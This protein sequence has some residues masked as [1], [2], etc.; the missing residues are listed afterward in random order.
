[1][2]AYNSAKLRKAGKDSKAAEWCKNTIGAFEKYRTT[3]KMVEGKN[4]AFGSLQAD[5]AGECAFGA[6]EERIHELHVDPVI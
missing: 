5:M 4:T 1:M 3:A 6:V 2:A